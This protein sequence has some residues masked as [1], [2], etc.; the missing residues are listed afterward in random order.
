VRFVPG[1]RLPTYVFAGVVRLGL[2]R[3][4]LWIALGAAL[5]TPLLVSA[6][7]GAGRALTGLRLSGWRLLGAGFLVV[8]ALW[9]LRSWV[10][11][12]LHL[13]WTAPA[14]RPLRRLTRWEFWPIWLFNA[15]VVAHFLWLALR[16][17]SMTC[18]PR[19]TPPF[20]AAAWC[21]SRRPAFSRASRRA[22]A[23]ASWRASCAWPAGAPAAA[24]ELA[25]RDF[26]SARAFGY[27]VVLKPDV[28]QRGEGVR[29]VRS[30]EAL[31]EALAGQT[32]ECIAQNTCPASSAVCS[33]CDRRAP[34]AGGCSRSP[35]SACR[36]SSATASRRSSG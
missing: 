11:P 17:R 33:T 7:A 9:L 19:R 29:I 21:A 5:W 32:E 35:A 2:V 31:P 12:A 10:L 24:R 1:L 30:A 27:P 23:T 25:V 8:A 22:T 14:A 26:L 36:A 3:F 18:S 15:P 34:S 16:H 28:G 13:A 20:R 4:S 6:S